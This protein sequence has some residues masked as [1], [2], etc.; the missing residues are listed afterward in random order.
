M[1]INVKAVAERLINQLNTASEQN[2]W[3]IEGIKL[4]YNSILEEDQKL[5]QLAAKAAEKPS[6]P[7][8]DVP[9]GPKKK[10]GKQKQPT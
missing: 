1:D 7:Q 8:G 6:E 2:K 5:K 10:S 9:T 3:A 4:F